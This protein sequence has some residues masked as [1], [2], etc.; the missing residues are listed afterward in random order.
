[1]SIINQAI[2]DLVKK[3]ISDNT[4]MIFSK[5]YCPYCTR[6]K[7]LFD[8]IEVDYKALELNDHKDGEAIQKVLAELTKQN[9]VPNIFVNQQHVG[10]ADALNAA[11][12]SGKLQ[13]LLK[14][15]GIQAKL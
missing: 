2:R 8:D 11:V 14:E 12:T 1:M 6:A 9:T 15:A 13:K 7:D 5:S 10:G 3:A 4:V